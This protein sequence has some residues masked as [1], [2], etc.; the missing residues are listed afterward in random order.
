MTEKQY[1]GATGRSSGDKSLNNAPAKP[2]NKT[3]HKEQISD[4]KSEETKSSIET[5]ENFLKAGK[6]ASEVVKYAKEFIKRDMLLLEIANKIEDKIAELKGKSAFPVN[7][8]IDET[9]AHDT[10]AFNDTRIASGLLKVDIGVHIEGCIADIAF[11]LDLDNNDENKKLINAAEEALKNACEK[12][13]EG[14]SIREVGAVIEKTIKSHGFEPIHN[15]SGHSIEPWSLHSG[16]TMPNHDNSRDI[17]IEPGIY[18]IEPFATTGLGTVRD[19]KPSGIYRIERDGNV[20]DAFA[21]EVLTFIYEEYRTLPFC[22]RWIQKRFGSRGL[23]ALKRIEEAGIVHHYPQLIE[24]SGKKVSQAEHTLLIDKD[25]KK[26]I[27][28]E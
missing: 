16:I 12:I 8:S 2:L 15:L 6:I 24:V 13:N 26:I 25:K 1:G 21:R 7:L 5:K 17:K 11:S 4:N 28:T 22:S 10:P 14:V 20:R 27:T 3:P 9:A 18:A 23:L 19:G